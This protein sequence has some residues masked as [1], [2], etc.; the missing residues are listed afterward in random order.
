VSAYHTHN[1]K[2]TPQTLD[3]SILNDKKDKKEACNETNEE[4]KQYIDT[5]SK[6]H[7]EE[8]DMVVDGKYDHHFRFVFTKF[9]QT[10]FNFLNREDIENEPNVQRRKLVRLVQ[11][12]NIS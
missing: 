2:Y 1:G 4:W 12:V 10:I 5:L 8:I 9:R 11:E 3:G 6:Y 7:M